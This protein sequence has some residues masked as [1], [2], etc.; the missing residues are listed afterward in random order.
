WEHRMIPANGTRI[1]AAVAGP[2]HGE[3]PL[4]V[5]LHAY[6]QCWFAWRHQLVQL[7]QSGYRVAA[8]DLRG[9]GASDKPPGRYDIPVLAD[10][11][12]AVI[13]SL[14]AH[15]ATV[16]GHGLGGQVA[17]ALPSRNPEVVEAIA[18]LAAP[19]PARLGR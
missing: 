15:R 11:V 17:W 2:D 3:A 6:P 1:H 16:A 14:G 18:V 8:L 13:R 9:Y 5:L 7:S 4:V 10:D 19:H 12:A